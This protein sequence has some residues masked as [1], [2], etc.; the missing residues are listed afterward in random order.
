Y[1]NDEDY[2]QKVVD[3]IRSHCFSE[4]DVFISL[5]VEDQSCYSFTGFLYNALRQQRFK[6]F[7]SSATDSNYA[8]VIGRSKLSI[9]VF[10]ERYARDVRYL[11][12]L[13]EIVECKRT[14]K[15][16]VF[17]VFYNLEPS[18]VRYQTSS[19]DS[20]MAT[21]EESYGTE[22]VQPWRSAMFEVANLR[23]FTFKSG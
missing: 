5:N 12:E 16:R 7:F 21:H 15:Q 20:A 2:L 4:I 19:Y 9:I 3:L 18:H 6:T 1:D 11:N 22:I 17:P 14:K 10:S 13:I 23:G 8:E